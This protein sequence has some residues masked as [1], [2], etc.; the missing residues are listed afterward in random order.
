MK[1]VITFL[2]TIF[3]SF[4]LFAGGIEN[5]TNMSTGY[6]RN[7][8]RN[9]EHERPEAAF[10]NIAGTG[11]MQNGLYAEVGNQFVIKEYKNEVAT[12]AFG[13]N[14]PKGTE[15]NDETFVYLYPNAEIVYKINS[16]AI[17]ANFGIYAGGGTLE[18][19]EG[20]AATSMAFLGMAQDYATK[21]KSAKEAA[22]QYATAGDTEKATTY[23]SAAT[24]AGTAATL[25]QKISK[26]HSLTVNSITYGEQV[27]LAYNLKDIV[28]FSA[29]V[30]FL[31]ATQSLSLESDEI[32][33]LAALLDSTSTS[34]EL[35]CDAKAFGVSPVFG[36]HVKPIKSLDFSA[37]LQLKTKLE[38]EVS[39]V[40]NPELAEQLSIKDGQKFRTD[41]PTALNIGVGYQ[42]IEP[43]YISSSFNYYFNK[44][45]KLNSILGENDYADSFEISVGADYKFNEK[46]LAS[47]GIA[48]GDQGTTDNSNNIFNPVLDSFQIGFGAEW[49]PIKQ[50]AVTAGGTYVKYFNEDY[51]V[52][53]EYKTELSKKLF[54][55][56]LG[57]TYKPF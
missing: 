7:P 55:F 52:S 3:A 9:T 14:L 46:W 1:K 10:Y 43:L 19:S 41:L 50:L 37:Q 21:A 39:N 12:D 32:P 13:D 56:S 49:K 47:L 22:T 18:Y 15:H 44:Y 54:M 36:I 38:Y 16:F 33:S 11:F 27:G 40:K 20:T 6:L 23:A 26:D 42:V 45:A 25:L 51:Y 5:K 17:F 2:A 57:V 48:Y 29:G 35:S 34:D 28:S 4:S 53:G 30:R 24:N 31:E 8:S